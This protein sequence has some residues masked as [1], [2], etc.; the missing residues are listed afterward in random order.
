MGSSLAWDRSM[1]YLQ[2]CLPICYSMTMGAPDA[3]I[4]IKIFEDS[5]G[6]R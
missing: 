2:L 1:S 3:T 4:C 5:S 6:H